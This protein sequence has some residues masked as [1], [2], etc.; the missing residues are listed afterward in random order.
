MSSRKVIGDFERIKEKKIMIIGA[1]GTGC[2]VSNLI[3]RMNIPFKIID[4]DIVDDTNLER[5]VLFNKE[6]LLKKKADVVKEKLSEFSKIEV[7]AERLNKENIGRIMTS[8]D[9]VIDCTDNSK[10]RLLINEYC[11]KNSI[12]WIY[13]GAVGSI[14]IIY[15]IDKNNACYECINEEKEGET[16][17]E[18]GVLNSIVA[19]V[20]AF[21]VNIALQYL[22]K[23]DKIIRISLADNSILKIIPRKNPRCR[24]CNG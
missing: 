23:E 4:D 24:V 1:G 14:G 7:V 21:T 6:D 15:L 10:T 19:I 5:Q 11:K 16:S 22:T 18:I 17:C 3:A 13:T 8:A 20:S 9:L 2:T 12:P